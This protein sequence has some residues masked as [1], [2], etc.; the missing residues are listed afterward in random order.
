M[1]TE[2]AERAARQAP[3]DTGSFVL[4]VP[5]ALAPKLKKSV[6]RGAGYIQRG[7]RA[8]DIGV[9]QQLKRIPGVGRIFKT[10][11]KVPVSALPGGAKLHAEIPVGKVTAPATTAGRVATPVLAYVGV[12]SMFQHGKAKEK[13]MA[14]S[15]ACGH[16][17]VLSRN[18]V[19]LVKAAQHLRLV[20]RQYEIVLEKH[21]SLVHQTE[22]EKVTDKLIARGYVSEEG[23]TEKIAEFMSGKSRLGVAGQL[24]DY[25]RPGD[26]PP[27]GE[28]QEPRSVKEG[29]DFNEAVE[30]LE[31]LGSHQQSMTT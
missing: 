16:G 13:K 4:D 6:A 24:A 3:K 15:D 17:E 7:G 21:A 28:L 18:E 29:A 10:T 8:V 2:G 27:I 30:Y 26:I 1:V 5:L 12:E 23:R 9:G 22:A 11:E 25:G 31:N 20:Q 14:G 19:L